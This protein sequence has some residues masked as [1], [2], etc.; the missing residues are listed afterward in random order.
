MRRLEA[1]RICQDGK[2]L[3]HKQARKVLKQLQINPEVCDS[4]DIK[5]CVFG[6]YMYGKLMRQNEKP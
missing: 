1:K 5:P 4:C 2:S 6:S 3:T